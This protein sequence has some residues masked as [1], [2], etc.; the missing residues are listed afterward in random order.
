M[1]LPWSLP[2]SNPSTNRRGPLAKLLSGRGSLLPSAARGLLSGCP[3][4]AEEDLRLDPEARQSGPPHG[5]HHSVPAA[6]A[7]PGLLPPTGSEGRIPTLPEEVSQCTVLPY[8]HNHDGTAVAVNENVIVMHRGFKM[9]FSISI[10]AVVARVAKRCTQ[11]CIEQ[12]E[13]NLHCVKKNNVFKM[14]HVTTHISQSHSFYS[15]AP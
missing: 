9:M 6:A 3:G 12:I 11:L 14:L 1:V 7:A 13:Q 15:G 5:Q 10:V 4:E 2:D 8:F